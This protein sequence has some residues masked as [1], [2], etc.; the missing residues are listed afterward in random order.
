MGVVI[1]YP[2]IV[3]PVT[4]PA[5]LERVPRITVATIVKD[6]LFYGWS[7]E[8][9]CRQHAYLKPAEA[10]SAMAY[11]FDHTEEILAEISSDEELVSK[12]EFKDSP[13]VLRMRALGKL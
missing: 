12:A 6:Y 11:F 7:I 2:H 10:H 3:K 9:M 13:F 5:H 4:A 1:T 8:E